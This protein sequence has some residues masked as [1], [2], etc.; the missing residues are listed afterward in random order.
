MAASSQSEL[1]DQLYQAVVGRGGDVLNE[2]LVVADADV[3]N[4]ER[5][6][7]AV[8]AHL[9]QAGANPNM[10]SSDG[11][12]LMWLVGFT[13]SDVSIVRA[14]VEYGGDPTQALM[15]YMECLGDET[16]EAVRYLCKQSG[17]DL[18]ARSRGGATAL[19]EAASRDNTTIMA[20]LLAAGA[21]IDAQDH[22]GRTPLHVAAIEGRV[23]AGELL[24]TRGAD[25]AAMDADGR[26][27]RQVME[28]SSEPDPD[29]RHRLR[30]LLA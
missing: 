3:M 15:G 22:R 7:R 12:A 5:A 26:T 18:K 20:I 10:R 2:Y 17:T 4:A 1:D 13:E 24:V 16:V 29:D 27:P 21:E 19:H 23:A 9:L 8:I 14:L 11:A 6:R 30:E 28:E 25:P